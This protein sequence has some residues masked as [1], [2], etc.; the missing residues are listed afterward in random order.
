MIPLIKNGWQIRILAPRR[1]QP[2]PWE[3]LRRLGWRRARTKQIINARNMLICPE[4]KTI[5]T[6]PEDYY[7]VSI[8]HGAMTYGSERLIDPLPVFHLWRRGLPEDRLKP[9]FV[10]WP[11]P[12]L[13]SA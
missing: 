11:L 5:F 9:T 13:V 7:L 12:T 8:A 2:R 6:R 3:L 10:R 4:L 1:V